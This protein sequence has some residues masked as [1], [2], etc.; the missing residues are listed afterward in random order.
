[1]SKEISAKEV[2][3][4]NRSEEE[5]SQEL[6]PSDAWRPASALPDPTPIKGW[7]FR[8]IRTSSL[9]QADNTNV[10]QKMREGWIPVRAED[11]PELKVMSDVESRFKGNVEVGGLLLCKIPEEE[12]SKRGQYYRDLAQNQMDAVDNSFL[13]EENPVMPLIKD[14]SSRTTYGRNRG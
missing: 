13:R 1:M 8:W 2:D 14:R 3:T 12:I 6:R 4:T 11:H 7:S 5:R 9:G 10:S